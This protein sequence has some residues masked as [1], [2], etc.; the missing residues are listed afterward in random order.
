MAIDALL[1]HEFG[2]HFEKDHLSESYYD[3]L[4]NIAARFLNAVRK[5][6]L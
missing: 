3:A 4:T 2:H 5:K 6:R 1:I